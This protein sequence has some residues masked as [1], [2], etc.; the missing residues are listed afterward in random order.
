MRGLI[1]GLKRMAVHDGPGL[2][3]T[4]FLKGCP[5]K[6]LWCHNPE[7]ISPRAQSA[8]YEQKCVHCGVCASLCPANRLENGRHIFDANQCAGCGRC[9]TVCPREAFT[10]YGRQVTVAQILPELMDDR[11]F[12]ET[13]GGGVTL[14]GGEPLMQP[15]FTESLLKTLKAE[16]IRTA[17]DTCGYAPRQVLERMLPYTDL[18]LFDLKAVDSDLH[19]RLT[20]RE[21]AIIL[22]NLRFL[23]EEKC[24]VEIRIPLIPDQNDGEIDAMGAVLTALPHPVTRVKVLPYHPYAGSKYRALGLEA[25]LAGLK[26][27][28]PALAE[29]AAERLRAMGLNAVGG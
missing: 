12:Y 17:L 1:T 19:R 9:E 5:L 4:L 8:F 23:S 28:D 7:G 11:I 20:G 2:R 18:F 15:A 3:T 6:C 25:P 24:A 22:D 26:S 27:L 29:A 13:S 21:N 14:S 10:F 16:G